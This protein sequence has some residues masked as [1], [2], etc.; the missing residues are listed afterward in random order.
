MFLFKVLPVK[1]EEYEL[2]KAYSEISLKYSKLKTK[3]WK[4]FQS[5]LSSLED[6]FVLPKSGIILDIGSGNGRNLILFQEKNYN[7]IASD[8]SFSLLSSLVSLPAQK[9][10]IVNNDMRILPLKKKIA[11]FVLLIASIHHLRRKKDMLR[12][13]NEITFVLKNEG[14]LILSCWR[15]W[16]QSTRKNM[17][18]DLLLF[19]FKK[20]L[21]FKW[22]HGDILL[23]WYDEKKKVIAKRYYHL[24][25]KRELMMIL[26]KSDLSICDF[27]CRGGQS[28]SDNFFVLLRRKLI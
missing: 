17:L 7:L 28:K 11:D 24:F 2:M 12:V 18:I 1:S 3:P 26:K 9:T 13:L 20:I 21:N 23:P 27:S 10:Q 6:K 4:D 5:Y 8:L 15:R 16:K 22:Q 19:P 25:T 14:Y